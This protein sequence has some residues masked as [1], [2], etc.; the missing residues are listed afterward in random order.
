MVEHARPHFG[1]AKTPQDARTM[2]TSRIVASRL[3]RRGDGACAVLTRAS[4]TQRRWHAG[5]QTQ[6]PPCRGRAAKLRATFLGWLKRPRP[7]WRSAVSY[8][9]ECVQCGPAD[10][11]QTCRAADR[12]KTKPSG[13]EAQARRGDR[14][15]PTPTDTAERSARAR[16]EQARR[17][18]QRHPP[19]WPL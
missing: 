16:G 11:A 7:T 2:A 8:S 4:L 3:A 13:R 6:K 19:L 5:P 12:Q 14:D 1:A 18:E 15:P 17:R 9:N 10:R